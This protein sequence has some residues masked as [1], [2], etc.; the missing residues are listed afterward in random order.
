M[1]D[2]MKDNIMLVLGLIGIVSVVCCLTLLID[3]VW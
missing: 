1:T 3:W 2:N